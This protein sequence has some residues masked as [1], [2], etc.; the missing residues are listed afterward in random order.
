MIP[1]LRVYD[2][3]D[4][5]PQMFTAAL[6]VTGK[7]WKQPE[8]LKGFT[9]NMPW[10]VHARECQSATKKHCIDSPNDLVRKELRSV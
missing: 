7:T 2:H 5:G 8:P 4:I 9:V 6:R 1:Q 3:T 10:H